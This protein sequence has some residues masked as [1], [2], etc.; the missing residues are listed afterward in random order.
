MPV[1]EEISIARRAILG[2]GTD[3]LFLKKAGAV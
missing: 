3:V 2:W 1:R